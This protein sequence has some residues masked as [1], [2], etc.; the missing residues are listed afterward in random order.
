M[1]NEV[2]MLREGFSA[3]PVPDDVKERIKGVTYKENSEIHM[4]DLSY[5]NIRYLDFSHNIAEG[6]MIVHK[7]LAKEVLEIFEMLFEAEYEIEKIRLCDEYDGD[8]E[9]S[10]AD[11]NS[12]AFNFRNVAGTQELSLHALGR[13][14]DINPLYNPYIVGEK[15]SP[16]NSAEFA[17]RGADFPHKINHHDLAFKVFASKGWQWGGDWTNSKD[18]Q[19]FYKNKENL[20][21]SAVDKIKKLVT[22]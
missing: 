21:K 9:R 16:A 4:D 11:N 1:K 3:C 2:I 5:L 7:S 20:V 19:H 13:A 6:E 12:S 22:E 14:I 17:D 15:I 18:Y 8:D 10:M